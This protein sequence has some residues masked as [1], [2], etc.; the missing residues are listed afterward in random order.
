[1]MLCRFKGLSGDSAIEKLF[2]E[3]FTP[4]SGGML[5]YWHDISLGAVDIDASRVF[6]WIELDLE[7]KDAALRRDKLIDA[8]IAATQKA[9]FDPITGFHKQIAVFTHNFSKDGAPAGADWQDPAWAPFWLDGSADANGRVSAPPHAHSGTFV[10]HEMGHGFG[11]EH[12]L[13][14]DLATQYSDRD[15]IMSAMNVNA[16]THPKWNVEFGPTMSFPQLATKNWTL[17][18]RVH[19]VAK[20]WMSASTVTTFTLAPMSDQKINASIGAI[21][22]SDASAGA[23]DYYLEYQR[24]IGWNRGLTSARLVIRRRS[25]NTGAYL[26]QVIVPGTVGGKASWSEPSGKVR[27]EVEKVRTDDRVIKV[28]VTKV[29]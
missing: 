17:P 19:T 25:G 2:K 16:F 7:R 3:M 12:D 20:N 18:R 14:A 28:A 21:L 29:P 27:F 13:G 24:P 9:G 26:G 5:E 8:A 6:G 11:Y 15:C 23:W 4:G 10:G 1:M 22:P